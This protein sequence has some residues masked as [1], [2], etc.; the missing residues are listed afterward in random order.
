MNDEE[1]I[2]KLVATWMAATQAGDTQT[3]LGLMTDDVLFLRPGHPP[4]TK[5]AFVATSAGQL[6]PEAPT[7]EAQSEVQEIE[8]F[9]DRAFM[10]T[11]LSVVMTPPQG[12]PPHTRAGQTLSILKK[13]GGRWR[14]FRDA[15]LLAP[16]A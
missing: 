9:G 3:I 16:V 12:G 6:K 1:E 15:N 13:Q 14:V 10:W 4:M 5:A 2:R 8:V 7:I 11:K